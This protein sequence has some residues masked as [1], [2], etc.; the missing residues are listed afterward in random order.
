M[1]GLKPST[2]KILYGSM[3]RKLFNKKDEIRVS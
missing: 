3:L 2:R 1:D